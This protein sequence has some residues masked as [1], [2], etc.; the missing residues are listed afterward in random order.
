[1]E[2]L[3]IQKPIWSSE[4]IGIAE[5]RLTDDIHIKIDY[6]DKYGNKPYP[7]QYFI[8]KDK[9][10]KYPV[11]QWGKR[12]LHIIPIKDLEILPKW[13]QPLN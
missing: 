8:K 10:L 1:M 13:G 9:A 6:T 5:D 2:T 11:Q 3:I 7:K 12:K 4:S